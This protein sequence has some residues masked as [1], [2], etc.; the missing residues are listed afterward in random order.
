MANVELSSRKP[1]RV[2]VLALQGD[3]EAHKKT[4]E[5]LDVETVEVRTAEELARCDGLVMPGGESTTLAKLMAR[6]GLDAE[7]I[8]RAKAGMPIYGTCAGLILLAQRIKDRPTQPTLGLM[9][10]EVERNAFGRQLDSFETTL[11]FGDN[12]S[13]MVHAVFIRAPYVSGISPNVKVLATYQ[14]KIVAVR[15][16]NLLGT[17]FHPE[18]TQDNRVHAN[19]VEMVAQSQEDRK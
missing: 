10:I 19:F 4:L 14:D 11:P 15:Q 3:F 1:I 5:T 13:P 2:G 9:E 8:R 12:A 7:I 17:A 16:G 18:L 6:I